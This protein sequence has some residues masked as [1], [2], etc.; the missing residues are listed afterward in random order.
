MEYTQAQPGR[1]FIIKF[2]HGDD[3]LLSLQRFI[4]QEK[5]KT[6]MIQLMGAMQRAELV[7]GPKQPTVPPVPQ[8]ETIQDGWETIGLGTV[9]SD[10]KGVHIHLH[11]AFGKGKKTRLGCL[12]KSS[13]VFLVIE[14]IVTELKQSRA[15]KKFD[16]QSGLSLLHISPTAKRRKKE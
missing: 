8:W 12:R 2:E 10:H 6:A 7:T 14:A 13:S 11:G 15:H 3:L 16:P 1:I 9:F 5:I 4:H